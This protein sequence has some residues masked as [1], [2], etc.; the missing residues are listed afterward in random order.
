MCTQPPL[1]DDWLEHTRSVDLPRA[2]VT[3]PRVE[4]KGAAAHRLFAMR[5]PHER[6]AESAVG[7]VSS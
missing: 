5:H 2:G 6:A 1:A 4:M 3:G 7:R